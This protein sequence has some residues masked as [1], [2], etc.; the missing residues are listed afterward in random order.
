MDLTRVFADRAFGD[1]NR[2]LAR[3]LFSP[4]TERF[5]LDHFLMFHK[6]IYENIMGKGKFHY[7]G[8]TPNWSGQRNNEP[9]RSS[10]IKFEQQPEQQLRKPKK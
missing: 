7:R 9:F 1:Q 5:L 8:D 10:L 4:A 3:R 6:E 2:Y